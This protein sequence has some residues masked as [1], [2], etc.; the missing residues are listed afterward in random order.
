MLLTVGCLYGL[1]NIL[2]TLILP[3]IVMK[4]M[5]FINSFLC[6]WPILNWARD[7]ATLKVC[8]RPS[9]SKNILFRVVAFLDSRQVFIFLIND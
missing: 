2:C 5:S 9:P 4:P 8:L 7:Q 6:S 3:G 1:E